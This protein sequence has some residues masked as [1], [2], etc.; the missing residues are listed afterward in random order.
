MIVE[1][2]QRVADF[3]KAGADIISVHCEQSS[4]I[5]LHRT[6]NMVRAPR[7]PR[8]AAPSRDEHPFVQYLYLQPP[9]PAH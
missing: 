2:E 6:L 9:Q 7:A 1:P 4:T 3:A 5:H 8:R